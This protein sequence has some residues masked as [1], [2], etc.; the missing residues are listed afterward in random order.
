MKKCISANAGKQLDHPIVMAA[1]KKPI[2]AL[3]FIQ[4]KKIR[5]FLSVVAANQP[6]CLGVIA[7][8][9][10]NPSHPHLVNNEPLPHEYF[11][12]VF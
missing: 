1:T 7:A 3:L 6:A 2:A 4:Q 5:T 9:T 8:I 10:N 12:A 11:A